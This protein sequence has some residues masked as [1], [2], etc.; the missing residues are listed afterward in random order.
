MLS[1][2]FSLQS[3]SPFLLSFPFDS[4]SPVW[5]CSLMIIS[6]IAAMS[7]NRVIGSGNRIPWSIPS[8]L[9]RFSELTMGHPVVFGRKTFESIGHPL[10]GRK[11]I[12]VTGQRDYHVKGASVVHSVADALSLCSNG[13]EVFIC[14]GGPLYRETIAR[15]D[16]IYLTVVHRTYE[17]E[18]LFPEIPA[19]FAEVSR[20]EVNE[21]ISYAFVRYER[22]P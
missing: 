22:R 17:G 21:E 7:E 18:I 13:E 20:E 16:R 3:N 9:K 2:T 6:L 4:I 1:F 14:G 8:D 5:Y 12:I 11:N 10:P 19:E 15:A